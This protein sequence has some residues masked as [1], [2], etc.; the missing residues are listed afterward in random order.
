MTGL[1]GSVYVLDS[2]VFINRIDVEGVTV[3]G[4]LDE[5]E[6]DGARL[7]LETHQP[8]VELPGEGFV[9]EARGAADG[10]GDLRVLSETDLNLLGLAVSL[11]DRGEEPIVVTDDYAVQNVCASL[12][13]GFE[14]ILQDEI[15]EEIEWEWFCPS[16]GRVSGSLEEECPVCGT[17][18]KRRA[19]G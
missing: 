7:F 5:I 1:A 18:L 17:E 8:E 6:E 11:R 15:D 14:S 16:C 3:P 9:G 12:G 2:T 4:V 13:I 19:K 10:T